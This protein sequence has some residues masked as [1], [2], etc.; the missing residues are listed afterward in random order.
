MK[1][2][3][4]LVALLLGALTLS[5]RAAQDTPRSADPPTAPIAIVGAT[6]VDG[7]GAAPYVGTVVL[8]GDRIADAGPAVQ[9]PA[10]ATIVKGDGLTL[11]PG[12]FDLHTHVQVSASGQLPADWPKS[13]MAYLYAG[14]TSIA[15]LGSHQEQFDAVRALLADGTVQGPRVAF[16]ARFSSPAG[17][18]AESGRPDTHTREVLTPR[19]ANDG[20]AAVLAGPKPDLIKVFTDGWRYGTAPDMSSMQEETLAALIVQAHAANLPVITHT[21]TV[22]RAKIAAR[23]GADIIGHGMN[24]GDVDAELIDLL[25]THKMTYV[26]TLSVYEPKGGRP[27]TPLLS[28]VLDPAIL[29][30]FNESPARTAA[31]APPT[32]R[33]LALMRNTSLLR[34]AGVTFGAGTDNGMPS[35]FHGWNTL[36]ELTL[37][38]QGGLTPLEA[39]TAATGNSARALRVD[40]DRGTIAAGRLA[41]L[42]LIDGRPHERIADLERIRTVYFAGRAVD[43]A[44]LRA[45]ITSPELAPL[46]ARTPPVL[47]DDFEGAGDRASNGQLWVNYSD[48]GHDRSRAIWTHGLRTAKNHTLSIQSRM[49]HKD[50]PYT[51]LVLPLAGGGLLPADLRPFSGVTFDAR[52]DGAYR[53]VIWTRSA[54]EYVSYYAPFS[55]GASWSTITIDFASLMKDDARVS[56]W[57]RDAATAVVFETSRGPG[58]TAWLEIDNLT[59]RK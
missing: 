56:T 1:R 30:A 25:K 37:L 45:R 11:I 57:K 43:R 29:E 8:R 59:L 34:Q 20:M 53:F 38:V 19:D 47:L 9:P 31:V 7:T 39:I 52:G 15:E 5:P 33:W 36:R 51:Q 4:L 21:V 49:A 23:A 27:T 18:G 6:I 3:A 54:R 12:L 17:H 46:P 44:K 41:D 55:A 58:D 28:E 26:P 14:V 32:R 48:S 13:L 22:A 24:D 50:R 40:K 10:G 2:L 35:T 16:A 42:V